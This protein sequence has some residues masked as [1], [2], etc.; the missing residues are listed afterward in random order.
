MPDPSEAR[1]TFVKPDGR[2]ETS[3]V[4]PIIGE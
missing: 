2:I 4:S 1:F 3:K